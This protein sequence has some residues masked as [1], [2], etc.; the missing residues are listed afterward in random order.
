M[1]ALQGRAVQVVAV[2]AGVIGHLPDGVLHSHAALP[3]AQY[4]LR[5]LLQRQLG[6]V[7]LFVS[8]CALAASLCQILRRDPY[9]E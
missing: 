3:Q 4:S 7:L 1:S 9:E 2:Q 6:P 5:A 8:L